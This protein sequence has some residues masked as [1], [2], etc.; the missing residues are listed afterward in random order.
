[1]TVGDNLSSGKI[2]YAIGRLEICVV[3]LKHNTSLLSGQ[4]FYRPADHQKRNRESCL[5]CIGYVPIRYHVKVKAEANPFLTVCDQ[6]FYNRTIWRANLA[7]E[8]EQITKFMSNK[9]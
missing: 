8:C 6:Y 7:K 2:E 1:M 4:P 5:Y 9:K 3:P